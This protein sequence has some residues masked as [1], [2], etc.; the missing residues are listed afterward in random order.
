VQ[1]ALRMVLA[2]VED[3]NAHKTMIRRVQVLVTCVGNLA[4]F[5]V[6]KN[7]S[8]WIND[9]TCFFRLTRVRPFYPVPPRLRC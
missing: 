9:V 6:K 2:S 7:L 1:G 8:K 5:L 3:L 4:Q